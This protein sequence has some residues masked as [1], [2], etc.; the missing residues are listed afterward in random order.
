M[1]RWLVTPLFHTRRLGNRKEEGAPAARRA[2]DPDATAV[3]RHETLGYRETQPGSEAGRLL[4][5]PVP[6]EDV[7]KLIRFY[8]R[9]GI[10]HREQR[11]VTTHLGSHLDRAAFG[12]EL[13]R[14][15]DEVT[16]HL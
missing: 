5:L 1:G 13:D 10:R 3:C 15:A 6:I 16:E 7:G 9:S 8:L 4:R 14:I 2:L 11:L 12:S